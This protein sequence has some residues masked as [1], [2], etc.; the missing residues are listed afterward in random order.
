M[1]ENGLITVLNALKDMFIIQNQ[2][3]PSIIL[4][5]ILI[6]IPIVL[7]QTIK[8]CVFFVNKVTF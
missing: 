7:P 5:V 4:D 1:E 6:K 2:M 8:I 3:A